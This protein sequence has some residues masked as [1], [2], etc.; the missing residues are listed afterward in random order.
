M[1][2]RFNKTEIENSIQALRHKKQQIQENIDNLDRELQQQNAT[3]FVLNY[4]DPEPNFDRRKV[5][6][7][8][9]RLIR[10]SDR[11]YARALEAVSGGSLF[12]V[13]VDTDATG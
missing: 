6:G 8:V 11:K 3:R 9:I 7:R 2:S 12:S 10:L 5:V 13:V 4:T 1:L